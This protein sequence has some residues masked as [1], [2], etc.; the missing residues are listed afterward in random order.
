MNIDPTTAAVLAM[1]FERDIV[2]PSG[3]FGALLADGVARRGVLRRTASVLEAARAGGVLVVHGRVSYPAGH[4]G[5]D[6][7][8]PLFATIVEHNTLVQGTSAI[9]I[10]DEV[11]P[12]PGDV[13]VDHTGMSAFGGGE[14]Q[15]LLQTRGIDTLIIAGVATNLI[16]DS[17]ARAASNR[18]LRAFVLAD[19]CSG[20]D[21]S[22]HDAS[23]ATL[24][25]IT[26]GV[27]TSDDFVDSL[28]AAVS[29]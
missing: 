29:A 22:S 4:P 12:A 13:I 1:H 21:D 3:T 10:V 5:L 23:L 18:G 11:A 9:E 24:N 8:I 15:R 27:I 19:C 20:S 2:D 7:A 26:H 14:L 16:V 28:R 25:M 17:T 6:T